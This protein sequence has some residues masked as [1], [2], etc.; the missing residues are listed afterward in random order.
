[1]SKVSLTAQGIAAIGWGIRLTYESLGISFHDV[2]SIGGPVLGA[3]PIVSIMTSWYAPSRGF[4][5]RK[6]AKEYGDQQVIEGCFCPGDKVVMVEDVVTTGNSL[7]RAVN[8]VEKAGGKIVALTAV[9]DRQ[10]GAAE[11]FKRLGYNFTSLLVASDL[12]EQ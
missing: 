1:M 10:E 3:A 9:L 4:Y 11:M 7:L 5:V 12:L 8:A 6:E 2:D